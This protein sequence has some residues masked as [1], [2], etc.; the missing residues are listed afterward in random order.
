ML[1]AGSVMLVICFTS[2]RY[3]NLMY[4]GNESWY[5]LLY[6]IF[7]GSLLAYSAYVVAISKLPPTLVS[8]YAYIN[9]VVAVV[10]GWLLLQEKMNIHMI[11]G[12]VIILV[13]V[14]LVNREYKKQIV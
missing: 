10:L 14:Y 8:V 3:V 12:T 1:V 9:P 11:A 13:S 6:L 4:A 5:A 2:G 7:F